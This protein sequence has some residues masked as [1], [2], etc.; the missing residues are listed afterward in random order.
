MV[1]EGMGLRCHL[2]MHASTSPGGQEG[3][4][5]RDLD[6]LNSLFSL[7]T[8]NVIFDF[9]AYVVLLLSS[10]RHAVTPT[11]EIART[12]CSESRVP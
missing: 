4:A 10:E 11:A 6:I 12:C 3:S 1:L 2:D 8:H 5:L 9:T 7:D